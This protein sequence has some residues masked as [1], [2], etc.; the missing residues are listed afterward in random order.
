MEIALNNIR[1]DV[2]MRE[3]TDRHMSTLWLLVYLL[4]FIVSVVITGYFVLSLS[5]LFSTIDFSDPQSFNY[6]YD[7]FPDEFGFI[8]LLAGLSGAVNFVVSIVLNYLLVNRR[9]AHFNRQKFLFDDIIS[10]IISLAKTKDIDVDVELFSLERTIKEAN[11]EEN[12]KSPILW[13]ILSAFVPFIQF[14]V[15]YFLMKD[16]YR[17]ERR[18]DV[19]WENANKAFN[20]LGVDSSVLRRTEAIPFRSFVLYLI[21]TVVTAG[22]FLVYWLYVLLKDPNKHF[23]YH[24]QIENKLLTTLQHIST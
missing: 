20:K 14:Y 22:M 21:L 4:P 10:A 6:S 19:F 23:K 11:Y 7:W 17:H 18:E 3:E 5:S 2:R 13:A 16:F 12:E 9:G 15:Y 24:T 1:K 8:W